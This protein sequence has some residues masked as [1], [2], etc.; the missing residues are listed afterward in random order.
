[1][2]T[3]IS[4]FLLL[5]PMALLAQIPVT[6][7]ANLTNN[8]VLHVENI[9]KWVESIAHLKQQIAQLDQQI[10]I[11]GDIRQW[12]GNP[13]EAGGKLILN[14]LG[15]SDLVRDYGRTRDAILST[16]NSL[17]SLGSTGSGNYRAIVSV[18]LNGNAMQRD[19]L[20]YRRYA[21]LDATQANTDQV[22]QDTKSRERE[23]QEQIATTLDDI[24]AAPTEAET[25]KLSAKLSALNGQL[26]Q[27]EAARRREVDAVALQKIANDARAEEERQAAAELAAKDDYLANQRVSSYLKTL[28]VRKNPPGE[29]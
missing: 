1:M 12:A 3:V 17:D 13:A 5:A 22:S 4:I 15:A 23:L 8:T 2:K 9:A 20:A 24:K 27:V 29:N 14:S 18:D 28:R 19:P 26:A 21:V 6:D 7:V 25:Q 10:S 16:V 11:Q